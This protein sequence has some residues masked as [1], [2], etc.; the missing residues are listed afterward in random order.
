MR[1]RYKIGDILCVVPGADDCY[2]YPKLK[3]I[4]VVDLGSIANMPWYAYNG[5]GGSLPESWLK[6]YD[7]GYAKL[8]EELANET[9]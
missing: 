9:E 1:R 4:E 2:R 8:I 5:D 6:P 7:Y 3:I